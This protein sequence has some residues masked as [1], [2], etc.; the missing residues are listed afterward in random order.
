MSGRVTIVGDKRIGKEQRNRGD[1]QI[2][3]NE[4]YPTKY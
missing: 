3:K 1:G 2:E 4:E